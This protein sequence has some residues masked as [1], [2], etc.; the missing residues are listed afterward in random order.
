MSQHQLKRLS[1]KEFTRYPLKKQARFLEGASVS[2][3]LSAPEGAV[4]IIY[5]SPAVARAAEAAFLPKGWKQGH[6]A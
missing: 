2:R 5:L 3:V 1:F 4:M 6:S